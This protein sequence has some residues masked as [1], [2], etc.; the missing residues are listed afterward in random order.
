MPPTSLPDPYVALHLAPR[1]GLIVSALISHRCS[2]LITRDPLLGF[3]PSPSRLPLPT[4]RAGILSRRS[5][6]PV[7]GPAWSLF[8]ILSRAPALFFHS[9]PAHASI[10]C[11]LLHNCPPACSTTSRC[12]LYKLEA[13]KSFTLLLLLLLIYNLFPSIDVWCSVVE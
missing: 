4:R 2:S 8:F 6:R 5:A 9:C 7:P 12:N 3:V 11:M 13:G 1:S 10:C